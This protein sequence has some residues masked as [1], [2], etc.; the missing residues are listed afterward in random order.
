[1][2]NRQLLVFAH[3]GEA[4]VFLKELKLTS[5]SF[6][7]D[8]L[9]S[10]DKYVLLI[11]GEGEITAAV[12]TASVLAHFKDINH[13]LNFGICGSLNT[14]LKI[15]D[16]YEIK[17]VFAQR[18]TEFEFKSFSSKRISKRPHL[19]LITSSYRVL[20]KE[21]ADHLSVIAPLVDRELWGIAFSAQQM[22]IPFSSIK[23]IS[24]LAGSGGEICQNIREEALEWSNCLYDEFLKIEDTHVENNL[25]DF[26]IP[27][28][29]SDF[30][31]TISQKRELKNLIQSFNSKKV[32]L[33]QVLS[34]IDENLLQD[35]KLRPKDKTSLLLKL[36]T[37]QLNPFHA[38]IKQLLNK[39]VEVLNSGV[40]RLAYDPTFESDE[41]NL[42]ARISH[43]RHIE[44][45]RQGLNKL[46]Y[47]KI[48][49]IL[50]GEIDV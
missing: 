37:E 36:M 26:Q 22:K 38:K 17:N 28:E 41:L 12:R 21:Q 48:K 50:R 7:F 31:F 2:A 19:D 15:K 44:Q 46:D 8:G 14:N 34:H 10:N 40:F 13:I 3:R 47:Q 30:H 20:E 16:C 1:M 39:E 23:L 35:K 24:D 27:Q 45:L 25:L 18:Q 9:Y 6:S 29:L 32:T 11:C 49:Q 5:I 43:D 4:Q 33:N 42:H